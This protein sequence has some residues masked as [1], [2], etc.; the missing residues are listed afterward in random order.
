MISKTSFALLLHDFSKIRVHFLLFKSLLFPYDWIALLQIH[1]SYLYQYYQ[2][3]ILAPPVLILI[4]TSY[5][6]YQKHP[7]IKFATASVSNN[8]LSSSYLLLIIPSTHPHYSFFYCHCTPYPIIA[9]YILS[10]P[11]RTQIKLLS[12]LSYLNYQT[13]SPKFYLFLAPLTLSGKLCPNQL[14]FIFK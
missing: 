6:Q 2:H 11:A 5:N 1:I 10:C 7:Y 4:P 12:I 3:A 9:L 14:N 13:I 8:T